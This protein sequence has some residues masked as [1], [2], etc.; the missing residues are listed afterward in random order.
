MICGVA[1]IYLRVKHGIL[2]ARFLE[3][4]IFRYTGQLILSKIIKTVATSCQI[5]RLK[6]TK[7]DFGWAPPQTL[8]WELTALPQDSLAG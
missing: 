6:C 3:K 1:E 4:N 2:T 7:I 5:S 8:L